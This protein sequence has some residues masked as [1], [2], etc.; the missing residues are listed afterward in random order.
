MYGGMTA[1]ILIAPNKK[2]CPKKLL[3]GW[4]TNL[5]RSSRLGARAL[6]LWQMVQLY[7]QPTFPSSTGLRSQ[8]DRFGVYVR[9]TQ[10]IQNYH[11]PNLPS[12]VQC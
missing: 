7:D 10:E 4:F 11:S 8:I 9:E 6:L 1:Y 5:C 12:K 3:K 2:N